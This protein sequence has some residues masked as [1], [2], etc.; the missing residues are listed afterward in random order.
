MLRIFPF[1]TDGVLDEVEK[2]EKHYSISLPEKYKEFLLKY[3]GGDTIDATFKIDKVSSDIH[4][5][6]G[7]SLAK[8][9]SNFN[10]LIEKGFLE[11]FI[12]FLKKIKS[13]VVYIPSIEERIKEMEEIGSTIEVDDELKALWQEEIDEFAGRE[14]VIVKL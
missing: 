1:K 5:F 4:S 7:F 6:Y 8:Y 12:E 13:P 3:N 10:Y 14:Q 11:D 2:M 9:Y